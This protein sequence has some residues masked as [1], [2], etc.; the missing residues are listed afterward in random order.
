MR[1][2]SIP[3]PHHV[4]RVVS[5]G[6]SY[7]YFQMGRGTGFAGERIRLFGEPTEPEWWDQYRRAAGQPEPNRNPNSFDSLIDEW[8]GS[9]AWYAIGAKTQTEWT[10]YCDRIRVMW[11]PL[12]VRGLAP[13]DVANLRDEWSGHS[14]NNML[15]CLSSMLR[16]SVE[17]GYRDDNPCREVTPL[18]K[19]EA[20]SAWPWYVIENARESL[21]PNLWWA[22]AIATYTGQRQA[23]VLALRWD[24][25]CDGLI[26]LKQRKTKKQLTIPVHRDLQ[27]VL[28]G[29][30]RRAVTVLTNNGGLPWTES[31]FRATWR[32]RQP[33]M[34]KEAGLVFHGLRKTAVVTLL[35]VGCTDAEVAAITGQSR[36]MIEHYAKQVNQRRLAKS[37][38]ARWENENGTS[39]EKHFAQIEK[40]KS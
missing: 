10:R 30:P 29:I 3:L 9:P 8:Q 14:A 22:V 6:K 27:S 17:K 34:A 36:E 28:D 15:R 18:P 13:K 7:Y 38:I 20:Y 24:A 5:R 33:A 2:L 35:E 31:G 23:D 11:G 1:K 40:R 19:G 12:E 32:K 21:R 4:N 26:T 37:A 25:I 39:T 16:W